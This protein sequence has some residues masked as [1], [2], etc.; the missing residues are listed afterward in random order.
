MHLARD[1]PYEDAL[2]SAV[3]Q[4]RYKFLLKQLRLARQMAGMTQT[5]AAQAFGKG[6]NFV[7]NCERGERRIDPIDLVDFAELYGKPLTFFLPS[8][9][10]ARKAAQ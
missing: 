10:K 3:H 4:P 7:S 1:P 8:K 5:E 2:L 9:P 6:Q